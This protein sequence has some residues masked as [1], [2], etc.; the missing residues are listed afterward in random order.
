MQIIHAVTTAAPDRA[1]PSDNEDAL[2][3]GSDWA[4]VLDGAGRYPGVTGGCVHPVTWIVDHLADHFGRQLAIDQSLTMALRLAIEATMDDH[5]PDC[6][7]DDP[8]SP[9][10]AVAVVRARDIVEWLVLGD[11]AAIIERPD[12]CEAIIDDRV[13][14][15]RAPVTDAAVRT[16][17]PAYVACVRNRPGGFW[18]AGSVAAAAENALTGQAARDEVNRVLLCSDG[19]SRLTER[20]GW[21]WPHLFDLAEQAGAERVIQAVRQAE[22]EDPDSRRWRGKRHDDATLALIRINKKPA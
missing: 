5:G 3:V 18:V 6:D 22:K 9:G 19:V 16:Y 21:T 15:L 11:C 7:L 4:L 1:Q 12:G 2:R 8:L 20:Y 14:R 17:D 13:D 10:A